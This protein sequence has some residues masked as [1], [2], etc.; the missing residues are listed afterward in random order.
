[1]RI[2]LN[3]VKNATMSSP[4]KQGATRS[5]ERWEFSWW[6]VMITYTM[7][8]PRSDRVTVCSPQTQHCY[9]VIRTTRVHQSSRTS[10]MVTVQERV[11]RSRLQ[12]GYSTP[13]SFIN[14]YIYLS[15]LS[16][17]DNANATLIRISQWQMTD[18]I[19]CISN[20][21]KSQIYFVLFRIFSIYIINWCKYN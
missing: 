16:N 10:R 11:V 5:P 6:T 8:E 21:P 14:R 2:E 12:L 20:T 19:W 17:R 13:T 4:A 1:M 7:I 18:I 9:Q 3:R 15:F